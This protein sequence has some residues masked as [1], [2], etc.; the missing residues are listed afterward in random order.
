[1]RVFSLAILGLTTLFLLGCDSSRRDDC[2]AL[3]GLEPICGL[4]APEDIEVTDNGRLLLLSHFG[5]L[6]GNSAGAIGL[7]DTQSRQHRQLFPTSHSQPTS[8]ELW[9]DS[10]CS[11]APGARFSPHGIHLSQRGDGRWQLLAVNHGD[12]EAVEFF[13]WRPQNRE[14]EWRGCAQFPEGSYLNDVVASPEGGLLASH[15]FKKHSLK[16]T[17][18]S[19]FGRDYG[20][21]W[22][23]RRG[24]MPAVL[25]NSRGSFANGLQLGPDGHT[26]FVNMWGDSEVVKLDR[27][28][29]VVLGRVSVPHPDNSSWLSDGRL[30]VASQHMESFLPALCYQLKDSYCPAPFQLVAIDPDTLETEVLFDHRG[31][32]MGAGT[33]AVE[34]LGKLFIGSYAGDRLLTIPYH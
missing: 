1:M 33:V 8:T 14:L 25:A 21:V 17:L 19:L 3:P 5:G 7:Y 6:L 32:P 11:T 10:S 34:S 27:R 16:Q 12:R 22:Y 31:A 30:L 18:G 9:G 2:Q 24:Q 4:Q 23:W 26:L 28:S 29:G 20:Y 15:M 13:E